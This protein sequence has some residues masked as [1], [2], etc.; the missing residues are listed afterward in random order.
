MGLSK[1]VFAQSAALV[2]SLVGGLLFFQN[3]WPRAPW[4]Q[5]HLI[6]AGTPAFAWLPPFIVYISWSGRRKWR[7][8]CSLGNALLLIAYFF[9]L[10]RLRHAQE[11]QFWNYVA[12]CRRSTAPACPAGLP[13]IDPPQPP[14][15]WEWA[16]V[17]YFIA[18]I[19]LY[20]FLLLLGW[21]ARGQSAR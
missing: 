6:D 1:S 9:T 21:R 20:A 2:F 10:N 14:G 5:A 13:I 19:G 16:A 7:L 17:A 15:Y 4:G 12:E 8:W 3:I 11:Q 18:L